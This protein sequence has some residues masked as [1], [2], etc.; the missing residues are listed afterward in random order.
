MKA[1][2]KLFLCS[3]EGVQGLKNLAATGGFDSAV[4]L[5]ILAAAQESVDPDSEAHCRMQPRASTCREKTKMKRVEVSE[6]NR[7]MQNFKKEKR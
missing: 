7:E 5:V 2:E 4:H 6:S 1:R 3:S